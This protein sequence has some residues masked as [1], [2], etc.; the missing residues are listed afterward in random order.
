[1]NEYEEIHERAE[2]EADDME[3]RKEQLG[4]HVEE[5]KQDW[6]AKKSDESVPGAVPEEED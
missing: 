4:K 6:E 5:T 2:R 3:R 1:V